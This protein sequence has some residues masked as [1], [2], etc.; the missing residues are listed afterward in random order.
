MRLRTTA[1]IGLAAL[2]LAS[3]AACMDDDS[4]ASPSDPDSS[5]TTASTSPTVEPSPTV[6]DTGPSIPADAQGTDEASA[7][8]FVRFYFATLSEAMQTGDTETL[9]QLGSKRCVSCRKLSNLISDT[10]A[11][12]GYYE[13]PGWRVRQMFDEKQLRL[14]RFSFLLSTIQAERTLFGT[15]GEQVD[16]QRRSE[17]P[18]RV[19]VEPKAGR[20]RIERLDIIR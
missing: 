4:G 3:L 20:W 13:T 1:G 12:G 18:M 7:K 17:V 16:T 6:T 19:I 14:G 10:Y 11:K 5:T 2:L 9:E 15:N 8:T